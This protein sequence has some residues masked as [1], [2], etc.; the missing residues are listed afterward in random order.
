[1]NKY[2]GAGP[3]RN[4]QQGGPANLAALMPATSLEQ[5]PVVLREA[6]VD[7]QTYFA[8]ENAFPG[9]RPA[10]MLMAYEYCKAR[11]LDILKKPVHIMAMQVKNAQTNQ[12]FWRDVIYPGI[13]ENR[14][15]A[16]RTGLHA[17]TDE[18][19]FGP[20]VST[21]AKVDNE[22]GNVIST[23]TAPEYAKVTVYKMVNGQR[24]AYTHIEFFEEAVARTK[25]SINS[26]WTKRP[27][28]QLAKCAEAGALRKAFPEEL[29]G[30]Y[31]AEEM[32]GHVLVDGGDGVL[33]RENGASGIP[34]PG[35]IAGEATDVTGQPGT[36]NAT[37]LKPEPTKKAPA[38]KASKAAS[39]PA[40]AA[41]PATATPAPAPVAAAAPAQ[42]EPVADVPDPVAT[43]KPQQE[44]VS[45]GT[46]KIDLPGGALWLVTSLMKSKGITDAQL[47]AKIG[48]DIT[49]KN[50]NQALALIK[51]WQ[52]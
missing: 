12:Y 38:K 18:P 29:G 34:E 4:D 45:P 42:P 10:S 47:L 13:A 22:S 16:S 31:T 43:P 52:S 8:L 26:M 37:Q 46:L 50:V 6:G 5:M 48:E 33:E 39:K 44:G 19:V 28:G 25:G 49:T 27:H 11:K 21:S 35:E 32:L 7:M 1:M 15:T 2:A 9:A 41:E 51:G 17:G 24:C 3:Q 20:N 30:E 14:I 36:E 40:P 23:M